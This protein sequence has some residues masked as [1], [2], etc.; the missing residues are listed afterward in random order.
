MP[1]LL[2]TSAKGKQL[3]ADLVSTSNSQRPNEVQMRELDQINRILPPHILSEMSARGLTIPPS[4]LALL[5]S[6]LKRVADADIR[7]GD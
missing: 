3:S 7:I 5:H 4:E 2:F 1:K 6:Q